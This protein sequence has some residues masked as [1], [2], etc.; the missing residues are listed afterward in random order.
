M[1]SLVLEV[2][3]AW[4]Y[5]L[6]KLYVIIGL[7]STAAFAKGT[8]PHRWGDRGYE[9]LKPTTICCGL[10]YAVRQYIVLWDRTDARLG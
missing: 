9:I 10:R 8:P 6:M 2:V 5:F 3:T 7:G 1:Y 4:S